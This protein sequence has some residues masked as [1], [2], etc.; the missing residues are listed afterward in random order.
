MTTL[1][2]DAVLRR[3][4]L[5]LVIGAGG[6]LSACS[7]G[8]DSGSSSPATS[9]PTTTTVPSPCGGADAI[10]AAVRASDVAG[11]SSASDKFNVTGIRLDSSDR[12]WARFENGPKPGITDFQGGYGIMHCESGAWVVYDLGTSEVG[13]GGGTIPAVPAAVRTD[14]AL[15]CPAP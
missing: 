13:C 11:L 8:G 14:L 5:V 4:G 9:E 2:G 15:E 6:V 3:I 10:E 12:T 7:G 1:R